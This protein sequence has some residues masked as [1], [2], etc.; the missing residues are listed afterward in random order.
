MV[1]ASRKLTLP[2]ASADPKPTAPPEPAAT[3]SWRDPE[4]RLAERWAREGQWARAERAFATLERRHE[5]TL[6][7]IARLERARILGLRMSTP[8]RARAFLADLVESG[9]D[10]EIARQAKLTICE[11]DRSSNPCDAQACL[12]ELE[13]SELSHDAA[14]L[15]RRWNLEKIECPNKKHAP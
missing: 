11:L 8:G 12:R 3:S 5:G 14:R 15:L 9:P 1:P 2:P 13:S 6:Q 4:W 7:R 10:D